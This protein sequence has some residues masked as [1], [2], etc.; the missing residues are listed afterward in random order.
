MSAVGHML[1]RDVMIMK[2]MSASQLKPINV[3]RNEFQRKFLT[4]LEETD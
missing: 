1:Y 2:G 4:A 3:I